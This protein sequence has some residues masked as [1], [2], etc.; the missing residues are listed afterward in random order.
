M[1]T[2]YECYVDT[3]EFTPSWGESLSKISVFTKIQFAITVGRRF[4]ALL[5]HE[6]VHTLHSRDCIRNQLNWWNN[7][8]KHL[9]RPNASD[10]RDCDGTLST[11][12]R[13]RANERGVI[14]ISVEHSLLATTTNP[15]NMY[16]QLPHTLIHTHANNRNALFYITHVRHTQQTWLHKHALTHGTNV[17]IGQHAAM[18]FT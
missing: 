9:L 1:P 8:W 10:D 5:S 14:S 12:R 2:L 15:R 18:L 17:H 11:R 16:T 4:G 6:N 7:Q 3:V 13:K